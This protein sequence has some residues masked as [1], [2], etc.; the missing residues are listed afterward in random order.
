M[1]LAVPWS[2]I[3]LLCIAHIGN[4]VAG[5]QNL[6][7]NEGGT[8]RCLCAL[9]QGRYVG[10]HQSGDRLELNYLLPRYAICLQSGLWTQHATCLSFSLT[11][12]H[13][14]SE[15]SQA[16]SLQPQTCRLATTL[17]IAEPNQKAGGA[18][19]GRPPPFLSDHIFV[20][21]LLCYRAD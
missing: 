18:E 13:N 6:S 1:N 15:L 11:A 3:S 21:V 12:V 5:F 17:Q 19:G 20:S 16:S 7:T 2:R 10:R 9:S 14:S 4:Y 8:G